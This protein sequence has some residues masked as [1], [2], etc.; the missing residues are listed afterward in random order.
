MYVAI[1]AVSVLLRLGGSG[2][3]AT[4]TRAKLPL[5]LRLG[6]PR[7]AGVERRMDTKMHP[8]LERLAQEARW[9]WS[10]LGA[11]EIRMALQ[12]MPPD[13]RLRQVALFLEEFEWQQAGRLLLE[14]YVGAERASHLGVKRLVAAFRAVGFVSDKLHNL[15]PLDPLEVFR[16]TGAKGRWYALGWTTDEDVAEWYAR[17]SRQ[18]GKVFSARVRREGVLAMSGVRWEATVLVDPRHLYGRNLLRSLEEPGPPEQPIPGRIVALDD[19]RG[20]NRT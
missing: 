4:D 2:P 1:G 12:R 18:P 11:S 15:R 8:E 14:A 5:G 17:R 9:R 3:D 10:P 19:F 6:Q 13:E 16:G 20:K 7:F